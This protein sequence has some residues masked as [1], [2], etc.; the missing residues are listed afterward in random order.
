MILLTWYKPNGISVKSPGDIYIYTFFSV[1]I[2]CMCVY[3]FSMHSISIIQCIYIKHRIYIYI[4]LV[5][6]IS[7]NSAYDFE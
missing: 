3:I 7:P 1:Y 4:Y 6:R 2:L 5:H